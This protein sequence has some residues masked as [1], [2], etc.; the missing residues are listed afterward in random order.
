[1][2][3]AWNCVDLSGDTK[4]KSAAFVVEAMR[5][6]GAGVVSIFVAAA[7]GV[8]IDMVDDVLGLSTRV[9]VDMV[10]DVLN[11]FDSLVESADDLGGG[12]GKR[13]SCSLLT[14]GSLG[15]SSR[16]LSSKLFCVFPRLRSSWLWL[17]ATALKRN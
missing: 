11:V 14:G 2:P 3:C 15:I 13:P 7:D 16:D 4:S 1:M 6:T 8:L 10:D 9:L 5:C 17:D 12:V